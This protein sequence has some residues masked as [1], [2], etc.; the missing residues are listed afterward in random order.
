MADTTTSSVKSKNLA[1]VKPEKPDEEQYKKDV[2]IAQRE[3]DKAQERLVCLSLVFSF[4]CSKTISVANKSIRMPQKLKSMS[5][6][7]TTRILPF[8][9][10]S[11]RFVL[12][13]ARYDNSSRA[14]RTLAR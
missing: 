13:W 4:L 12:S 14:I 6:A 10:S 9:K 8:S 7:T 5:F 1:G 2:E 3:L 11:N